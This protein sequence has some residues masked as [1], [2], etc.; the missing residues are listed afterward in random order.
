M[1]Q[2]FRLSHVRI[3]SD[4]CTSCD[5]EIEVADVMELAIPSCDPMTPGAWLGSHWGGKFQVS[6][7]TPPLGW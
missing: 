7:L 6:G 4:N 3:C 5:I 2:I 1:T